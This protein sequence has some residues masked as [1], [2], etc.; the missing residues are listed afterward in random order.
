MKKTWLLILFFVMPFHSSSRDLVKQSSTIPSNN[1]VLGLAA[2][3]GKID[4][5]IIGQSD[6]ALSIV[7]DIRYYGEKFSLDN[8]SLDYV[9]V[10]KAQYSLS[11]KSYQNLDGL[12]F[13]GENR[14]TLSAFVGAVP[15]IR[16]PNRV[17]SMIQGI[18][19]PVFVPA[20]E[21][22]SLSYMAG[23][24]LSYYGDFI[25]NLTYAKDIS[26][27]HLGDEIHLN[28]NKTIKF[29]KHIFDV[30]LG[31]TYKDAQLANY[32]YGYREDNFSW[33]ELEYIADETI[34][35]FAQLSYSYQFS[36]QLYLI[37]T[38][39]KEWLGKGITESPLVNNQKINSTF[40]G[41]KWIF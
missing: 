13:P 32:Y 4:S 7:P 14:E 3:K 16:D 5:V 31:A 41:A 17:D 39:K 37:S 1:W 8:L 25:A 40:I 12:Y 20:I 15:S 10:D 35:T 2:G 34:N 24:E 21:H 23:L 9:L 19:E 28:I 30:K 38:I 6:L 26:N 22:K 36:Q 33:Y 18:E 29:N 27:V 11:V